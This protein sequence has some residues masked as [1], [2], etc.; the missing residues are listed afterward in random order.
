MCVAVDGPTESRRG[1]RESSSAVSK[2]DKEPFG[3]I[4]IGC[5]AV[6][7]FERWLEEDKRESRE[8]N[9]PKSPH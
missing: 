9:N 8:M 5:P 7:M 6:N 3:W 1:G 4:A 2:K